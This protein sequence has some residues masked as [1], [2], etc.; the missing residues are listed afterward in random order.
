[1][2][3]LPGSR[4][5][6]RWQGNAKGTN[7]QEATQCGSAAFSSSHGQQCDAHHGHVHVKK[8]HYLGGKGLGLRALA[9]GAT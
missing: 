6:M 1:M 9:I 2:Q 5:Q 8:A 3:Q 7:K 4:G